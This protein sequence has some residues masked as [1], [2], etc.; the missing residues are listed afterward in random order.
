MDKMFDRLTARID[1]IDQRK[2]DEN[3]GPNPWSNFSNARTNLIRA[4]EA[5]RQFTPDNATRQGQ[6]GQLHA[7]QG[8]ILTGAAEI[9]CNGIPFSNVAEDRSFEFDPKL[10]TNV[11]LYNLA[12]S[13]FDSA[14][15][16]LPATDANRNLARVGKARTLVN[17]NRY[18]DAATVVG[19]GGGGTGSAA[20]ATSYVFNAEFSATGLNNGAWA[21]IPASANMGVP[22]FREGTNGLD[23]RADPRVGA[24]FFR[25][26][27]DG[28]TPVWVPLVAW[29][30]TAA[31][32]VPVA[33]GIEAR[34]I[35]AEAQLAAGNA[36]AF[37]ATLNA[38][39]SG[40]SLS[41]QL[42]ALADPGTAAGRVDLLF[43]ERAMWLYLTGHRLGDLRRLIRQYGRTQDQVFP[44]GSYFKGG[45]Y[46]TDVNIPPPFAERN[47]SVYTGCADRN[48]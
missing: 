43:A 11:E 42:P 26:G 24:R 36:A 46:G 21:W 27:Q 34:L 37:L 8:L 45:T 5:L 16:I 13:Q 20:V 28:T 39:R 40:S 18:A 9:Y 22:F 19:A 35:E 32:P 1:H 38:L 12:L 17:L 14:L 47:N 30:Q 23:Y 7:M 44:S 25:N 15:A 3:L 41:A 33:S 29:V 10:Y 31:S 4:R 2:F 48:A 6:L